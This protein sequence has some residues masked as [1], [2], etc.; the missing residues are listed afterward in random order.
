VLLFIQNKQEK[1]SKKND[2]SKGKKQSKCALRLNI[3]GLLIFI[4]YIISII[5]STA[6]ILTK[7]IPYK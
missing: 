4:G 6:I 1:H 7:Y 3:A 5:V 2:S